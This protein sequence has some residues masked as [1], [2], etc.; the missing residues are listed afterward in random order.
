[1]KALPWL[2]GCLCLESGFLKEFASLSRDIASANATGRTMNPLREMPLD[3]PAFAHGSN[4]GAN[5]IQ[6]FFRPW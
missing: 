1:M 3:K 5:L 2:E 6:L 4:A